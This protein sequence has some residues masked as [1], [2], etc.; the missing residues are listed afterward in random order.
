MGEIMLGVA[1][2]FLRV[3]GVSI[4]AGL[5]ENS[6]LMV[7]GAQRVWTRAAEGALH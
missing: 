6:R 2:L 5:Y 7:G 4:I 1:H 3:K